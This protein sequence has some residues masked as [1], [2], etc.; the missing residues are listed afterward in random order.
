MPFKK[1][2]PHL[3]EKLAEFEIET[4]TPFQKLAIP[5][6]KSGA[7][8]FC[9]ALENSGKTTTLILTTLNKLKCEEV[10]TAPRAIV[11]AENNDKALNLYDVFLKYSKS[12]S[13]RVYV[14]NERE[15]IDL[16]KSEIFE[17]VDVLIATPKTM[18][19][20][21]LLEG[22]NTTQ[23][24]IF[25]ID[26]ADFLTQKIYSADVLSITQSISKCQFVMYAQKMSPALRRFEDYFMPFAKI[27]SV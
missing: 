11:L 16:L 22:V 27:V 15:H 13:V 17:G 23:V 10:G 14:A 2:H 19:K 25:S 6:I 9:T 8:V 24:K 4:P 21:L 26:D 1:L 18:H 3:K 12:S 7:N 20:L 5:T